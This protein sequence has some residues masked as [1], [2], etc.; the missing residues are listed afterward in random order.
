[1]PERTGCGPGLATSAFALVGRGQDL[2]GALF[3][4]LFRRA[5]AFERERLRRAD[6]PAA[7]RRVEQKQ[8]VFGRAPVTELFELLERHRFRH[9]PRLGIPWNEVAQDLC[10]RRFA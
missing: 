2:H 1:M 3:R 8:R 10:L 9:V 5:S 6:F 4:I 7:H